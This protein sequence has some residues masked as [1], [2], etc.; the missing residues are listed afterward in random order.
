VRA[1]AAS[2]LGVLAAAGTAAAGN[3]SVAPVRVELG[4]AQSTAI[5]TVRNLD[6]AAIVVQA[7]PAAWSQHDGEDRLEDTRELLVTPPLFTIAA[8]GQQVLRVA[9]LRKPDPARELD[10]R[11]VLT[12][13]PPPPGPDFKGL[14]LALRITLPAFVAPEA[15]AAPDIT[16][17]HSWRADGTLEI[18]AHNHGNA[19]IQIIDFDVQRDA[20]VPQTLHGDGRYLLPGSTARWQLNAGAG[21]PRAT[22]LVLHGHSDA[23]DFNVASDSGSQ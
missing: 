11:L 13:V 17:R 19:H 16:W 1:L 7:R 6:D 18:E 14:R 2:L 10:Y 15:H 22:H 21:V 23:G 4:P 9:L 12:E 20:Q 3:L 8:K 5:I